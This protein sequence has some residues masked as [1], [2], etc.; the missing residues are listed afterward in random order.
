[1]VEAVA[2][3]AAPDGKRTG[4]FAAAVL[5]T[6]VD[7]KVLLAHC[8]SRVGPT[9]IP[10]R[11]FFVKEFPRNEAGKVLRAELSRQVVRKPTAQ[12]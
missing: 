1:V 5:R 11:I 7:E 9:E 12:A 3:A 4:L 6:A 8:R 2:F 10:A